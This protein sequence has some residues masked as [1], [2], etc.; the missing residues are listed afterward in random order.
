MKPLSKDNSTD[1]FSKSSSLKKDLL[2]VF[3]F[4][5][6]YTITTT[7]VNIDNIRRLC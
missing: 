6:Q 3:V 7:E 2:L 4:M 5:Y 1:F